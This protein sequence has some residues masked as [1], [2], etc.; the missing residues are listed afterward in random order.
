MIR[1]RVAF[2]QSERKTIDTCHETLSYFADKQDKLNF[3]TN[4]VVN[5]LIYFAKNV[6]FSN[7]AFYENI[8]V[9]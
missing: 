5:S 6:P 8:R 3:T 9:F 7:G 4:G 2:K 1:R